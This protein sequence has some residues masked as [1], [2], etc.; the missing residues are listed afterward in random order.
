MN[1][2]RVKAL[3]EKFTALA[4]ALTKEMREQELLDEDEG[5]EPDP[6][7]FVLVTT[8]YL[9]ARSEGDSAEDATAYAV[10]SV[11][12]ATLGEALA[13]G[14]ERVKRAEQTVAQFKLAGSSGAKLAKYE[15]MVAEM[16]A[17]QERIKARR[18]GV[19]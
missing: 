1:I 9:F 15:Q 4:N 7:M 6:Q 13:R 18:A 3:T 14:D 12:G 19:K 8:F 16:K 17:K 10:G 2:E 11:V 5:E